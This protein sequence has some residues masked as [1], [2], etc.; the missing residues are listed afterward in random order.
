MRNE[1]NPGKHLNIWLTAAAWSRAAQ[2]NGTVIDIVT[3]ANDLNNAR[4]ARI[5]AE[6][7]CCDIEEL[8]AAIRCRHP[9][10]R[11]LIDERRASELRCGLLPN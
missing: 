1:A 10:I 9:A 6:L 8:A 3:V 11:R 2:E 4:R 5:D 7:A